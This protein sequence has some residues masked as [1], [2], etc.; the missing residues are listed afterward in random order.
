MRITHFQCNRIKCPVPHMIKMTKT[1]VMNN[2][3]VYTD[4]A[5]MCC[6][7]MSNMVNFKS[8]IRPVYYVLWYVRIM[9]KM[10]HL[11]NIIILS[12]TF[13]T[14]ISNILAYLKSW[15]VEEDWTGIHEGYEESRVTPDKQRNITRTRRHRYGQQNLQRPFSTL[16]D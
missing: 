8:Y 5:E 11:Q 4:V 7:S 10:W 16:T 2:T 1:P 6:S 3:L 15:S 9:W 13:K 14:S 12:T